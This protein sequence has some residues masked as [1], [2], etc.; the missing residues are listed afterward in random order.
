MKATLITTFYNEK[1]TERMNELL[2]CLRANIACKEIERVIILA[3][4]GTDKIINHPKLL[5]IFQ[6]TRPTYTDFFKTINNI[7]SE[8]KIIA[9]TDIYFDDYNINLIKASILSNQCYALSRWDE[10]IKGGHIHYAHLDS[11][12]AWI[13]R[14]TIR[15]IYGDFCTGKCGCDNRIAHEIAE[16]GYD[17]INPSKTIKSYHLHITGIRNYTRTEGEVV[18]KPYKLIPCTYLGEMQKTSFTVD[19]SGATV[20]SPIGIE[21]VEETEFDYAEQRGKADAML[22]E[23]NIPNKYLLSIV[24]PSMHSR[25]KQFRELYTNLTKQI[26]KNRLGSKVEI[27]DEIDNGYAPIGWKRNKLVM[28]CSGH[29]VA[30]FDDDDTPSED[31]V[32][33]LVDAIES[34]YGV[35]VI[36][37]D[38]EVNYNGENKEM[39]YFNRKYKENHMYSKDGK[40]WR[41][42]MPCHLNAIRRE[43]ALDN[44]FHVINKKN[45]RNRKERNDSGSDVHYSLDMVNKNTL[46]TD[47]HIDKTLYYYNYNPKK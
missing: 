35:D 40:K 3:E 6:K 5:W 21:E 8:I 1:V 12:D 15:N 14:G 22:I 29:Y 17:V 10:Q 20:K 38:G 26:S 46:K 43:C 36:T 9:N 27:L 30:H 23:K 44:S 13:F 47:F 37:F 45:A 2:H 31:Y 24:V 28:E 4:E 19:Y 42:R 32:T 11:Q 7:G 25:A 41:E 39:L 33:S 34:N 16:A 18:P